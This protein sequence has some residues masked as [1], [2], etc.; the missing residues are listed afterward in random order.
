MCDPTILND[1]AIIVAIIAF[2]G[3]FGLAMMVMP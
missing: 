3:G 2:S 1:A